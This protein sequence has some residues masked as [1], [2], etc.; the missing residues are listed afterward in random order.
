MRAMRFLFLVFS[1]LPLVS[2]AQSNSQLRRQA[3]LSARVKDWYSAAQY[4]QRL[5][6]ND[7]TNIGMKYAYAE[8]SRLAGDNETALR[9]YMG[10][11]VFDNG[12]RFPMA[13]YW[14]G[15]GL[16]TKGQYRQAKQ[17]FIK[18]G[19]LKDRKKQS[20]AYY[21]KRAAQEVEH[22]D[23]AHIM[24]NNPVIPGVKQVEATVNT[25]ASEYAPY[26]V[27]SVLYF[28]SLRYPEKRHPSMPEPQ[29]YS[30]IYQSD[31]R[32]G[33]YRK[34]RQ[35]DTIINA[36]L[37]HNANLT[38]NTQQ[39]MLV[40]SRCTALNFSDYHCDLLMSRLVGKK[41][42]VPY[43]IDDVNVQGYSSTQP[44]LAVA[45]SQMILFFSSDRPGGE[46]GLDIWYSL[47]DKDGKFSK[48]QN[49]GKN[50]NTPEDEITPWFVAG[51]SALYFS[52]SY[53][54][55]MGGQD[56]FKALF[57]NGTFS[58]VTNAG[59]PINSGHNDLYYSVN[60]ISRRV[61]LASNRPGSFSDNKN[62]CCNDIY[63]FS[64]DTVA[65]PAPAIDSSHLAME[66][67]RLLVPLTLYFHN[68]E[69]DPKTTNTVTSVSYDSTYNAYLRKVPEYH[70]MFSTDLEKNRR[71]LAHDAIDNF[72][73]DSVQQGM[74]DLRRF[75][76]LMK[77]LLQRGD[78][79]KITM[80][81]YCSPL[82]STNYNRN[83]ARR[84]ISS[85][86]NYFM[87]VDN[88]AL[89][90]YIQGGETSGGR[91]IFEDVDI[92][93]L[94]ISK[95][96]DNFRDRRNSIYSPFAAAERKIQIIAVGF[97]GE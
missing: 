79:V 68:D 88:A 34:M 12:R 31:I 50:V 29:V 18:F 59:H 61:Y 42:L 83:L 33:K 80:K 70:S 14:I 64:Y 8:T 81:G 66:R 82:A 25:R 40:M 23:M 69:P 3:I 75:V 37:F 91:I 11:A 10:I 20:L 97:G 39:D 13:Y 94:K 85:L 45:D 84:R 62:N 57:R 17:W 2:F 38:Y 86:R 77:P 15:Q 28:S 74:A 32:R 47:I 87:R 41:W 26:E 36:N 43:K 56:I 60:E 76:D 58:P 1:F 35:L 55:G 63:M 95:A 67:M 4:Y 92:G 51:E 49:A 73:A 53:H 21:R 19:K 24:A 71:Q 54:G 44:H 5:Y 30:K 96:S 16:K 22:C 48:P 72:F 52:S 78:T 6:F 89:M 90:P 9:L 93:E 46:G 27:D 65:P 7:S